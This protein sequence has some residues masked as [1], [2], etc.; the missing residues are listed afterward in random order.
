M[1]D[2]AQTSKAC[3]ELAGS[4]VNGIN[5]GP[6]DAHARETSSDTNATKTCGKKRVRRIQVELPFFR[7]QVRDLELK[8]KRLKLQSSSSAG[9]ISSAQN[10]DRGVLKTDQ[11][12]LWNGIAERQL[13]ERVCVEQQ[14]QQ[15]KEAHVEL[16]NM[17]VE[18]FKL[19]QKCDSRQQEQVERVET[20]QQQRYWDLTTDPADEVYADQ[21]AIVAR[22]RLE[23]QRQSLATSRALSFRSGLSMGRDMVRWDP[24]VSAGCRLDMQCGGMLPFGLEVAAGAYWRFFGCGYGLDRHVRRASD[25]QTGIIARSFNVRTRYEGFTSTV[26]GKYT[27]RRYLDGDGSVMI[28][29]AGSGDIQEI[30]GTKFTGTQ[31]H[32][33]GCI[34]LR[35]V[36][37][38]GPGQPSTSTVVEASFETVP[39][40]HESVEDKAQQTQALLDALDES[41][42]VV[43]KVFCHRMGALLVEED[44]KATFDA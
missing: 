34:K 44:W 27:A 3:G 11:K 39:L 32:K 35:R 19:L 14:R 16:R 25:L 5:A 26:E 33:R 23:T 4:L 22:L 8:V 7:H 13:K 10:L 43:D 38:Q 30:G 40:F 24:D 18:M 1:Q 37:R 9:V 6:H 21:L 42:S 15:L 29:W 28:V 2:A 31:L 12:S 20:K 17:S 36:P 41:Y